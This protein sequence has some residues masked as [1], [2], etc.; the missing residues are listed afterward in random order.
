MNINN[1]KN[2]IKSNY[3]NKNNSVK[4]KDFSINVN[5]INSNK[6]SLKMSLFHIFDDLILDSLSMTEF[7]IIYF[8]EFCQILY[9]SFHPIYQ[10]TW[11]NKFFYSSIQSILQYSLLVP[12][13]K[14]NYNMFRVVYFLIF[15]FIVIIYIVLL[16][17]IICIIYFKRISNV[18]KKIVI[19]IN[20]VFLPIL[21]LP[22]I[23]IYG[24]IY[25]CIYKSTVKAEDIANTSENNILINLYFL[26]LH[27]YKLEH[28]ILLVISLIAILLILIYSFILINFYNESIITTHRINSKFYNK[29]DKAILFTKIFVFFVLEYINIIL[30]NNKNDKIISYNVIWVCLIVQMILGIINIIIIINESSYYNLYP[31]K[32]LTCFRAIE[33]YTTI[34]LLINII[35][36]NK[37]FYNGDVV[38]FSLG[39]TFITI[40]LIL[41]DNQEYKV[42][43][44]KELNSNDEK[45]YIKKFYYLLNMLRHINCSN[46]DNIN[47]CY[48]QIL[49]GF[50]LTN[51]SNV[52]NEEDSQY[53]YLQKLKE[54]YESTYKNGIHHYNQTNKY[55]NTNNNIQ[56]VPVVREDSIKYNEDYLLNIIHKDEYKKKT[57]YKYLLKYIEEFYIKALEIYPYSIDIKIF[58]IHYC[59]I[60]LKNYNYCKNLICQLVNNNSLSI[61]Q[62]FILFR[63]NKKL[64]E[65][66]IINK[67]S[68]CL[69]VDIQDILAN[70]KNI[71]SCKLIISIKLN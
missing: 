19:K 61:N 2:K 71:D 32:A 37:V 54:L 6:F 55:F 20:D 1:N 52:V 51:K 62:E 36:K 26:E 43:I 30:S 27:C 42:I 50:I 59:L 64:E 24:S 45:K 35:F 5:K 47:N 4:A 23:M 7:F 40:F 9:F 12:L 69:N 31:K 29:C 68:N 18:L 3:L 11:S 28:T 44:Y 60:Y 56:V 41:Y 53:F 39:C 33:L 49:K 8:I 21:L 14:E 16:Y 57:E 48:Y 67:S 22:F 17:F 65:E 25:N 58:Y 46:V 10:N 63:L 34:I 15:A 66:I 38:M 70:S 13:F